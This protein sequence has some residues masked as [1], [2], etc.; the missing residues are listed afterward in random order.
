MVSHQVAIN[1]QRFTKPKKPRAAA[2]KKGII[3]PAAKKKK[4]L[5]EDKTKTNARRPKKRKGEIQC[6]E[7]GRRRERRREGF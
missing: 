7:K 6:R 5:A 4:N 3:Q 2:Q 1:K